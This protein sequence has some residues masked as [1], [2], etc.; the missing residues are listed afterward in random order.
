MQ[1]SSLE[2][3][4]LEKKTMGGETDA[5]IAELGENSDI[6]SATKIA[7]NSSI[8][9][10]D[11]YVQVSALTSLHLILSE[12]S[13]LTCTEDESLKVIVTEGSH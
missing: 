10:S 9:G 13:P 4:S 2:T 1:M 5:E 8:E 3:A 7:M 6:A 12:R 11:L